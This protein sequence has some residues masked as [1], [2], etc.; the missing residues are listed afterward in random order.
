[1][2]KAKR[3]SPKILFKGKSNF[4]GVLRARIDA[5]FA[6]RNRRDDPRLYLKS[7]II[8]TWF[9]S[10]F[11]LL[12]SSS[13]WVP[14]LL[15][16]V[17]TALAACAIG[18]NIF[19]D[20]IHQSFSGNPTINLLLARGSCALLGVSRY[21]WR[22]KHNVLHHSFTN[23]FQWDDDLETRGCLRMSPRQPW[24]KKFKHQH[25]YCWFLYSLATIEWIF[26]KDFIHYFTM[27]IN[28]FQP[29]PPM[30]KLD[31]I[32][33]WTSKMAYFTV[34]LGLPFLMQP[35]WT[36]VAG[37]MIFHLTLGLSV[38]LIFN[39]AHV[40]EKPSF[41]VPKGVTL[42]TFESE[43]AIHQLATTVNF[44]RDNRLLT[45]FSGC[46]NYQ[47]EHHLFPKVSHTHYPE[48][49]LILKRT[50][51]EFGLPY[52][53]YPTYLSA[54]KSHFRT[55]KWLNE[56][57]R[58]SSV[59]VAKPGDSSGITSLEETEPSRWFGRT[60]IGP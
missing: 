30:S 28:P 52:H 59:F 21:F 56:S 17:S 54:L 6:G 1:M 33:F 23:V 25:V 22:Y 38:T 36:C 41:P 40:M 43:W 14:Q 8:L 2:D 9:F 11:A 5:H 20:S 51:Q 16:C 10:S 58:V 13:D 60:T 15:L 12:L 4:F 18:F 53:D 19:H 24:E 50:A 32:E 3:L 45:W 46:L 26:V 35:V 39:L 7:V 29:Y 27:R 49:S 57:P 44:G 42:P 31:K 37:L 47:I 34:F 55:L 48:M